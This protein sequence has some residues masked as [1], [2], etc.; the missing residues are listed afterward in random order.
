MTRGEWAP[1]GDGRRRY[2]GAGGGD[3]PSSA[4]PPSRRR[5]GTGSGRGASVTAERGRRPAEGAAFVLPAGAPRREDGK[6]GGRRTVAALC[7]GLGA[8]SVPPPSA[9]PRGSGYRRDA[10]GLPPPAWRPGPPPL[11]PSPAAAGGALRSALPKL[12]RVGDAPLCLRCRPFPYAAPRW[13]VSRLTFSLFPPTPRAELRGEEPGSASLCP[14]E[15]SGV[16]V[17][18]GL[19][20]NPAVPAWWGT[21]QRRGSLR[22]MTAERRRPAPRRCGQRAPV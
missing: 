21:E 2:P 13:D 20:P 3:R 14:C 17:W 10:A 15:R 16:A 12:L 11:R 4:L 9:G 22:K 7:R 19:G 18:R 6:E 8:T 1:S 5:S